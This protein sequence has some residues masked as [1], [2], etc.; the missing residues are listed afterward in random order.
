VRLGA[1]APALSVDVVG[2]SWYSLSSAENFIGF[3]AQAFEQRGQRMTAGEAIRR[4]AW[5]DQLCS[6][7]R[8]PGVANY[9]TL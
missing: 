5:I 9:F 1:N 8:Q 2:Q 3:P 6:P 7:L 4:A